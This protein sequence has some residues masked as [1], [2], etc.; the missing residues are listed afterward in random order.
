MVMIQDLDFERPII[1]LE[2]KIEELKQL[3]NGQGRDLSKETQKLESKCVRLK[4]ETFAN[5]TRWQRTLLAR[6]PNRPY[7]MDYISYVFQ[8]FIELH[9][10]RLFSDDPSI[11]GGLGKL[12]ERSILVLG[13]Q[14]GRNFKEKVYRN[15]GMPHPEGFR[16]ALRLFRLAD[17]FQLPI[18]TFIDTPGAY[19]GLGAEERGQAE[20]IARNLF[21]MAE[22]TVPIISVVIGEGGS[23]G[24]LALGIG[25]RVLMLEY[26]IYSVISPEGCAAILWQSNEKAPE[27]S[28]ALK[29]TAQ[30]LL[31]LKV[32][33]G[34]I[35]EPLGGAHRNLTSMA[36]TLK[37]ALKIH[38]TELST[39]S[40]EELIQQ[41]HEKFR[42]MG[43][44]E[45]P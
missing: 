16:K 40:P 12:D 19:P 33:D 21:V 29:L 30:D 9:G 39:L 26:A 10:D 35:K 4:E 5:L 18:I 28:E 3:S 34:I 44:F 32:I 11:V 13:Q 42:Q 17:K 1:E 23:G 6:H 15:F 43:V 20:A 37:E 24:G 7:T 36:V 14:K 31:S 27:A 38:L 41:R 8:N 25:N 22:L 45:K 2:L